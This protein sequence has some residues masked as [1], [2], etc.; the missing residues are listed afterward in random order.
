MLKVR[1]VFA[2]SLFEGPLTF[3]YT[4][5][6]NGAV[7]AEQ[8]G[9]PKVDLYRIGMRM[10]LPGSYNRVKWYGRGPEECYCDRK[11]G[12]RFGLYEGEAADLEHRYMRPQ[13]NGNRCDVRFLEITDK[14]GAGI[15]IDNKINSFVD[16]YYKGNNYNNSADREITAWDGMNFSVHMYSQEALD[17]AEHIFELR[18]SGHIHLHVDAKVCGVG[19]DLP[20]IA[21]LKNAYKISKGEEQKQHF[22]I[23][24]LSRS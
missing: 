18:D 9:I 5:F 15:R 11:G 17:M 12:T 6:E 7:E 1:A 22:I 10:E 14:S 16:A 13:E 4:I 19:G 24:R 2:N 8:N 23:R 3:I 20:G 21:L